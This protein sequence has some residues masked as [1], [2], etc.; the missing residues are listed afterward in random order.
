MPRKSGATPPSTRFRR[1]DADGGLRTCI[2]LVVLSLVMFTASV[3]E[4]DAG[5]VFTTMRGAWMTITT[6]IRWAGGAVTAPFQGLGNI[7]VNL[8]TDQE[9]L[10]DLKAENERL[11][12]RNAELEESEQTARRLESLLG[13]QSLYNLQSTGARIISG[14]TD[15][16]SSTVTIDKG[17]AAGVAVGM[18]VTDSNG[19]IGQVV[20][21]GSA[22]ATVRLITDENSSVSAMIQ[23]SRAQGVL[24]GSVDG[25]LRLT[26]VRTDQMVEVGDTV[27][28]SG[29]GGVF[30]KGL[31]LGTVLSVERTS[32]S[33]YY[34]IEVEPL[35][36][37]ESFEEVL[38]I[39]SLTEDQKA[40]AEDVAEADKQD[41]TAMTATSDGGAQGEGES[42]G[43][44]E[45]ASAEDD[46]QMDVEG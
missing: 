22:S 19:A 3:R 7:F 40:T 35:S 27:V 32:G 14:S 42:Q 34:E 18:P 12:A 4:G 26:L 15:S 11:V 5:G 2:V 46:E 44:G 10:S 6:P 28:T 21:C 17:S 23:S 24:R 25:S 30:P 36:S 31:P 41:T 43:D 16:W 39:T 8:T 9:R 29:L 13:L 45:D 33:L 1:T 38:V 37:T 20:K